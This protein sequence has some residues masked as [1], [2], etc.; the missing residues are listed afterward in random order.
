MSYDIRLVDPVTGETLHAA[1]KHHMTGGT[2]RA[3]G[4]TELSLNI[5]YNYAT[6][7]YRVMDP[8]LGIREIYNKS[9]ADSIPRLK[10]AAAK[11]TDEVD[12]DYWAPA[13]GNVK[14]ALL[15]LVALAKMRPDGVWIG[16]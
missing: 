13:E 16:D 7:F 5:T 6:T 14:R 1:D 12:S 15:Q 11:L 8:D 4:D 10:A 9:G 2:Y 3:G